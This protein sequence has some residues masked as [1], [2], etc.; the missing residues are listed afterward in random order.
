MLS[1]WISGLSIVLVPWASG[2]QYY[3]AATIT[4]PSGTSNLSNLT[5]ITVTTTLGSGSAAVVQDQTVIAG[6]FVIG[7]G[8]T[9]KSGVI[10]TLDPSQGAI[11]YGVSFQGSNADNATST[12]YSTTVTI[13][14]PSISSLSASEYNYPSSRVADQ[15]RGITTSVGVAGTMSNNPAGSG[16]CLAVA[17]I[18]Y[19]LGDSL[20]QRWIYLGPQSITGNGSFSFQV[21]GIWVS[22]LATQS[23]T[24]KTFPGFVPDGSPIPSSGTASSSFTFLGP[25]IPT[26]GGAWITGANFT[27]LSSHLKYF[28][29]GGGNFV[30]Q[31][32]TLAYSAKFV[33]IADLK[34]TRCWVQNGFW[35][36]STWT[37]DPSDSADKPFC[38]AEQTASDSNNLVTVS[39]DAVTV[40]P[41]V[42][43][44]VRPSA[45]AYPHVRI[46]ID[47][48]SASTGFTVQASFSGQTPP[49]SDI[50][51]SSDGKYAYLLPSVA[52]AIASGAVPWDSTT[53]DTSLA[54][55][56]NKLGVSY[57]SSHIGY[58]GGIT[59]AGDI[60][61]SVANAVNCGNGL[62]PWLN[63]VASVVS[64]TKYGFAAIAAPGLSSAGGSI[65]YMDS[66]THTLRVSQNG[67][68][69]MD[70]V[71]GGSVTSILPGT[72]V[73]ISG[74]S[75]VTISI[76]QDVST[77]AAPSFH[78]LTATADIVP[79]VANS[80]NCGTGL[81]P[82]L[83]V[84]ASLVSGITVKTS[85]LMV[86]AESAPSVSAS[87][88]SLIYMDSTSNKLRVSQNGAA[89]VDLLGGGSVTSIIPGT[90]VTVS[91]SGA[92]TVSIGQDVS[93]TATPSFAG[94]TA[95]AAIV[96]STA[97]AINLG[98]GLF[99]WLNVVASVVSV[100]STL[101]SPS[102]TLSEAA[103]PSLPPSGKSLIYADST[104][105][106]LRASQNGG[107]FVD[108]IPATIV[109]SVSQGT[110]VTVTGTSAVTISIGQDVSTTA[111]PSFHGITATADVTPSVANSISLGTGLLPWLN[112]VASTV[113]AVSLSGA[114][115]TLA[116]ESSPSL[117]PSGK[118]LI[119]A[120][121][122]T[123][124]LRASLNGAAFVDLSVGGVSSVTGSGAGINVSPTTGAV[125]VSNTGVTSLSQGT[126][127]TISSAT[128]AATIS[129]GQDVST[130]ATPQFVGMRSTSDVVPA[131]ANSVNLGT[132]LLP[133]LNVVAATVSA[134]S[135]KG[136]SVLFSEISA[137][138]LPSSGQSLIYA[139]SSTHKLRVSLSGAAFV[140][141]VSNV[142][143]ITQGTGVTISGTGALTISIGQNVAT[144]A[145]PAFAGMTLSGDLVPSVANTVNLGN[146]LFPWS[147]VVAR[148]LSGGS[149]Q[150]GVLYP[151]SQ[152]SS[153]ATPSAGYAGFGHKSGSVFWYYNPSSA[154]WGNVDFS[155]SAGISSVV[156]TNPGIS[157]STASG[158]ATVSN[159]GVISLA[160]LGGV[161]QMAGSPSVTVTPS[162]LPTPT[163]TISIGQ[164]VA[165]SA[166]VTFGGVTVTGSVWNSIQTTGGMRSAAVIQCGPLS[167]S[168][169]SGSIG[170][171]VFLQGQ[172]NGICSIA[173][174]AYD[175]SGSDPSGFTPTVAAI[176]G[177][178]IAGS[179]GVY[180][181]ILSGQ[182][183]FTFGGRGSYAGGGFG[184]G[185]TSSNSAAITFQA[186]ENWTQIANGADIAFATV[187]NGSAPGS[188]LNRMY[189]RNSG[190]VEVIS[191]ATTPVAP[192]SGFS[193]LVP[194]S[195]SQW[196]YFNTSTLT[197]GT[198]DFAASGGSVNINGF[199]GP[200]SFGG[201]NGV[202]VSAVSPGTFTIGLN[203]AASITCAGVI[204]TTGNSS[205][206]NVA[207]LFGGILQW[208]PSS[209]A[210]LNSSGGA[211]FTSAVT[212]TSGN[213]TLSGS[214]ATVNVPNVLASLVSAS[215]QIA[216]NA[217]GAFFAAGFQGV[218]G[219][220][221]LC[222]DGV[223]R[224]VR[225]GIICTA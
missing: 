222:N 20:G 16:A 49:T 131:V 94:L 88:Q 30:F 58:F 42:P 140:D 35:S 215:S 150:L 133:W 91:G 9:L 56:S 57:G 122:S 47:A 135:L 53:Y 77:T 145:A 214:G 71:G 33:E 161:V 72:G 190:V 173:L 186:S 44:S 65:I 174:D 4:P 210:N 98:N 162:A 7:T 184:S 21:S 109:T 217:G 39:G 45:Y 108:L 125:I 28:S 195:G 181:Q 3:V 221:V 123:H 163:I 52:A 70:L 1:T 10:N 171:T 167:T 205:F 37:A 170:G 127:V 17:W 154:S 211:N 194:K 64:G 185:V 152:G 118:S 225:G 80:I 158:V 198:V 121:S 134:G 165:T 62:F 111:A 196:Q 78:G 84:V 191:I 160:G 193:A 200:F 153:P 55:A 224:N 188:R 199:T 177:R 24:V 107:A 187:A 73:S 159:T 34:S 38:D 81:F 141:L 40:T 5:N 207:L 144:S 89:F 51:F 74:T 36:G 116:E 130:T 156:G 117:P 138:S 27:G 31:F 155:A 95:T 203:T 101:S 97:N 183:I 220:S 168:D 112:V 92:V 126:G 90:G 66:T 83:N 15:Q 151:Q 124:K 22:L 54:V 202:Q 172:G 113:S 46:H 137:P 106:K 68:A 192:A 104:T 157:V 79:S 60:L 175:P 8:V 61:P 99:P 147:N 59:M 132:G 87:G 18:Y 201:T 102:L 13:T 223:F 43:W 86:T 176:V 25:Q 189:I 208:G 105:H 115:L 142:T 96:P 14:P 129:I 148:T 114:T 100:S 110:G 206:G 32:G 2:Y 166:F 197:W 67:S 213:L 212:I 11:T 19:D 209:S 76:G 120:D 12:V 69:Y 139:D 136:T 216:V 219:V 146:G 26:S 23:A 218:S 6:P 82:W 182:A 103:A 85:N 164:S 128:G 180:S 149:A 169:Q 50:V 48:D 179:V 143:S 93:T 41:R 75:V 119:Y 178:R 63:L 29:T 204:S